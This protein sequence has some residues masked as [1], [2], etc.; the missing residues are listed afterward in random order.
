MSAATRTAFMLLFWAVLLG[1]FTAVDTADGAARFEPNVSQ[2][3]ETDEDPQKRWE[4]LSDR[5]KKEV[6]QKYDYYK[7]LPEPERRLLKERHEKLKT[8]REGL[9][10]F[11]APFRYDPPPAGDDTG[12]PYHRV[13][14]FLRDRLDAV[15]KRIKA[16]SHEGERDRAA[17]VRRLRRELE[18]LNRKQV[19]PFLEKMVER[20]IVEPEEVDSIRKAPPRECRER[21]FSVNKRRHL[22]EME[23]LLPPSEEDRLKRMEPWRFH[24]RMRSDMDQWGL[25]RPGARLGALTHEQ[26]ESLQGLRG[27]ERWQVRKRIVEENVRSRLEQCGVEPNELDRI[28][29]MP[30]H[31]RERAIMGKLRA[32]K[33]EGVEIPHE[34]EEKPSGQMHGIG[35]AGSGSESRK[36]KDRERRQGKHGSRHRNH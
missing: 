24:R 23:G 19:D 1:F 15:K 9:D 7:S 17:E 16:S 30:R 33:A 22:R 18:G 31:E 34:W 6:L 20:G 32:L 13:K 12:E 5:E 36:N 2:A 4:R 21:L 35:Y 25:R 10:D 11:D 3:S 26:E 28:F 29:A 8:I 27:P 14:R